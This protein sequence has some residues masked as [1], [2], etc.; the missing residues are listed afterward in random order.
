MLIDVLERLASTTGLD[1]VR[2]RLTLIN[3]LNNGAKELHQRLQCN[4]LMWENTLRV[5]NNKIVSLPNYLGEVKGIRSSISGVNIDLHG[6]SQPRYTSYTWKYRWKNWRDLGES[7]V[8]Q[9]P[10]VIAPLSISSA[11]QPTPITLYISG[12]T[13]NA[14]RIEEQILLNKPIIQTMNLFGPQIYK[15]ACLQ[16]RSTDITISDYNGLIL[17]TLPN[18]D[19]ATRYKMIDVSQFPS[20]MDVTSPDGTTSLIDVLYKVPLRKLTNDSDSFPAGDEYDN[21]WYY[22]A[23][24]IHYLPMQNKAKEENEALQEAILAAQS[25]KDDTEGSIEKK[26]T[27]GK[28][29]F[30]DLFKGRWHRSNGHNPNY[31]NTDYYAE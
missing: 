28:N 9:L 20:L 23:L 6:M 21:A 16:D 12:Q 13:Q 8:M 2:Q 26:L 5:P 19:R 3:L 7:A 25:V 11:V 10:S 22:F 24:W 29:R 31:Y 15:I 17:A 14:Y 30:F 4:K 1:A 27:F 18:T